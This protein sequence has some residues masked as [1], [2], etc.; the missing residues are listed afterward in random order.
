MIKRLYSLALGAVLLAAT[1]VSQAAAGG[2]PILESHVNI[3]DRASLQRGAA[4][5]MNYCAGCHSL[6]Y[7]RYSRT[8]KDLGLTEEQVMSYLNFTGAK[9]GE[10]MNASMD[11]ADGAAW[12]GKAPPDLSL[13]ARAKPGGPD[14]TYTF[15][16]SFY[17]DET[18]PAGWNNTV[19]VG[20]SMPNVLW[21]LQG[22]QRAVY[23]EHG[24]I[25]GFELAPAGS[26]SPEEFDRT[27]RDITAFLTYVGEPA[28]LKREAYGVWVILFLAVFTFLAWLLKTEYWRDVH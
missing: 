5:F 15:L 25:T 4:L 2:A 18:R 11:P 17:V 19:L 20:A 9:F 3:G 14:W 26:Q 27:I 12:F 24:E 13:V 8:A 22:S 1:G 21:N 6:G 28:A 10:H 16:K 7:Q 23:G